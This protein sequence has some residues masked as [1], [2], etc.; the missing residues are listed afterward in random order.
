MAT[1]RF[2]AEEL[3]D[4]Y[5]VLDSVVCEVAD[6]GIPLTVYEMIARLFTA[7]EHG[8]AHPLRL[9]EAILRGAA[10]VVEDLLPGRRYGDGAD[11][12][13]VRLEMRAA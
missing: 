1:Y 13:P 11:A 2:T 3:E 6:R 4:F 9:R 8:V 10:D 12:K 5:Q 7:A